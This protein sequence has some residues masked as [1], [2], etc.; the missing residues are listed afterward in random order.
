[1]ACAATARVAVLRTPGV[2]DA[3]FRWPEATGTVQYDPAMVTPD[4]II[5]ELRERTGYVATV[6]AIEPAPR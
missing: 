2:L 4:Q 1:M 5:S 6:A 3:E